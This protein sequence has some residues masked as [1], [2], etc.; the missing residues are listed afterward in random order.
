VRRR[1]LGVAVL[2]VVLA[3]GLFGIPLAIAVGRLY[4]D[5]ESS[6][7]E[8][9][10]LR[11]AVTVPADFTTHGTEIRIPHGDPS[12]HVAVYDTQGL[13]VAGDGPARGDA[14][15]HRA[16]RGRVTDAHDEGVV[17]VAV[18][19]TSNNQVIAVARAASSPGEVRGRTF[20]AWAA[21]TGLAVLAGVVAS[22]I[23]AL[24]ARRLTRPLKHLESVAEDLGAGDFST[25]AV[26]SGVGEIDRTGQALNVTAQRLDDLLARERAFTAQASHQ[27]RT[28][29]TSLRLGLESALQTDGDLRTAAQ[30][31]IVSADQ[32]S[33]TVDDVLALARGT[34]TSSSPLDL[35]ALLAEVRSRWTGPLAKDGR[36]LNVVE[37]SPPSASAAEPA[38]RQVLEVLLDNAFRHGRGA[39]TVTARDGGG[40]LAIDVVDEG[41][42]EGDRPL[43]PVQDETSA[44]PPPGGH[45][46]GLRMA[47]SLARG[48]GGR[49]LHAHTEP[50]TRM[51][52]LLPATRE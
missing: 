38:V 52:L 42:A 11:T 22:V 9:V 31:A 37:E 20:G 5:E 49:L 34:S 4:T 29:L 17:V 36:S 50:Q 1:I 30:E 26:P 24:Q 45:R 35:T 32:L 10:A 41:H 13:R 43:V 19:V 48:T 28:P 3:V 14:A 46:M 40:A 23:A 27:L 7:L 2:A 16:L 6:E 18:P 12:E 21:M 33:R 8:R 25:R 39:V 15:V 44:P 51:T 47:S